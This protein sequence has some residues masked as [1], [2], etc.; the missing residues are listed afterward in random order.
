MADSVDLSPEGRA[1]R[2]AETAFVNFIRK[3]HAELHRY[4][5]SRVSDGDDVKDIAQE[6]YMRLLRY[7]DA[8]K[9]E[10]ALERLLFRIANN[11]LTDTWRV[12][13]AHKRKEHLPLSAVDLPAPS[14]SPY[15]EVAGQQRLA[16]LKQVIRELPPKCQAVFVF[17]RIDGLT[18]DQIARK[19]GISVKTVEKHITRALA[20]CRA[21]I[22]DDED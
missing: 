2:K 5:H 15:R 16:R 13:D 4:L 11:L 7:R 21:E 20:A 6:C 22:G 9:S 3:H 17:S 10:A 19:C 1:K 8:G 14:P 12:G 18:H